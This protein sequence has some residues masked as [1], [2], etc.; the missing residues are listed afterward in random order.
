[1]AILSLDLAG[2]LL[3]DKFAAKTNIWLFRYALCHGINRD[4]RG[5]SFELVVGRAIERFDVI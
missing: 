2:T 3:I 1:M 5:L 4:I